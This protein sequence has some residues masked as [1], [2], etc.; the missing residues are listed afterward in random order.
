MVLKKSSRPRPRP[1]VAAGIGGTPSAP[2]LIAAQPNI[3][4]VLDQIG[5][6]AQPGM[7]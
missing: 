7:A 1:A 5:I 2:A 6:L 3:G 4:R